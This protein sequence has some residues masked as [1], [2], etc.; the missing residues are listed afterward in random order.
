MPGLKQIFTSSPR[1]ETLRLR[2]CR[3][4]HPRRFCAH[5]F[6]E[7][8]MN[9][10]LKSLMAVGIAASLSF[11]ALAE[12]ATA[13]PLVQEHIQLIER[14][15]TLTPEQRVKER[16]AM[17]EKLRGLTPEQRAAHREAV[18][19]YLSKMPPE[20]RQ[21]LRAG[22]LDGSPADCPKYG[23][24]KCLKGAGMNPEQCA[25]RRKAMREYWDKMPPEAREE[26]RMKMHGHWKDMTPE[27]RAAHRQKMRENFEKI[28][29]E[30]RRNF[31]RGMGE[32]CPTPLEDCPA[33]K[34]EP[35]K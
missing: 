28:P 30:E 31:K 15:Q 17:H 4:M 5:H 21:S 25:E 3:I 16:E 35:A 33:G 20:A 18:R 11:N 23:K 32:Y 26:W 7:N 27:E 6:E 8:T 24:K 12:D 1:V 9:T 34:Q 13:A 10:L 14:M 2:F 29:P 22:C 19:E